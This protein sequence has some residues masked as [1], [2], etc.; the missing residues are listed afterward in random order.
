MRIPDYDKMR[1]MIAESC[2]EKL[3]QADIYDMLMHG[4]LGYDRESNPDI[5]EL[6]LE[7]FE[8]KDIPKIK[9][10]TDKQQCKECGYLVCVCKPVTFYTPQRKRSNK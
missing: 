3:C 5:L 9:I 10:E 8:A 1:H 2:A 6:F 4:H 7:W